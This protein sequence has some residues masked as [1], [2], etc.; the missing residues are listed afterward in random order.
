[1]SVEL[2]RLEESE[3]RIEIGSDIQG[4]YFCRVYKWNDLVAW[5]H[6]KSKIMRFTVLNPVTLYKVYKWDEVL[7]NRQENQRKQLNRL[8]SGVRLKKMT[9][10]EWFRLKFLCHKRCFKNSVIT[11]EN[12]SKYI[13]PLEEPED[14]S[15]NSIRS[16]IRNHGGINMIHTFPKKR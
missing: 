9:I 11:A 15:Y 7:F 14:K 13:E 2:R 5:K 4:N 6:C 12:R 8:L 16:Y 3:C 1:M 10:K